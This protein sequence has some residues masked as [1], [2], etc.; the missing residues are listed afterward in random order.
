[1]KAF[2]TGANGHVGYQVCKALMARGHTVKASVRD[3]NDPAKVNHLKAL[4]VR[5]LVERD[6]TDPTGLA[7]D[8]RDIDTLFHVAAEFKLYVK[9]STDHILDASVVGADRVLRAAKDAAVGKVV[10]TSSMVTLPLTKPGAPP[11]TEKDWNQDLQVPYIKAKTLG[12]KKAW[13]VAEEIG[14]NLVT[15]LPGGIGGPDFWKNTPTI[16][17]LQGMKIGAFRFGAPKVNFPYVDVRDVASGHVLAAESDCKGRFIIVND[18]LPSFKEIAATMHDI[19]R[20]IPR[21]PFLIP[22]MMNGSLPF[23][24]AMNHKLMGT[25]RTITREMVGTMSGKIWNASNARAKQELGWKQEISL[26]ESLADTLR[27]IAS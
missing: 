23:F 2:V 11:S 26:R 4:G 18:T 6:V 25:P 19:D 7:E 20:S 15:V 24:D 21:A 8:L 22:Q 10:L 27:A 17:V 3:L 16:D 1:M 12:E 5:D 14:L 9:G 13:E